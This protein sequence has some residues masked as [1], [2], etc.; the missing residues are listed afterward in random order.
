MLLNIGVFAQITIL[1]T[2]IQKGGDIFKLS[3]QTNNINSINP[4]PAGANYSWNFSTLTADAQVID[5]FLTSSQ[6]PSAYSL[7]FFGY[8]C[9]Q[10]S[11]DT[12]YINGGILSIANICNMYKNSSTTYDFWGCGGT[13]SGI[14]IPFNCS[15]HDIIYRFPMNYGN[16][17]SIDSKL[18]ASIPNLISFKQFRHRVNQVDG[19][20]SLI[21]PNGI[22][23]CLRLKSIIHDIDSIKLDTAY[24]HLP[25][26]II[27]GIQQTTI[28]YKWLVAGQGEP[29]LQINQKLSSTGVLTTNLVRWQNDSTLTCIP[30]TKNLIASI[31]AG[32]TF[33]FNNHQLSAAGIY[34]DTL[35]NAHGCDSTITLSLAVNLAL[36]SSQ[37]QSQS[38][39]IG[40]NILFIAASTNAT[41]FKWQTNIGLGWQNMSNAGQYN[42]VNNDTLSISS[43]TIANNNQLFRCIVSNGTCIDTSIV[44]NLNVCGFSINQQ[45]QSQTVAANTN[46]SFTVNTTG[47]G[48]NF[49]WQANAGL[50]FNNVSNAGS[51]S[52]SNTATLNI[53]NTPISFNNY[54][55]HCIITDGNCIDT[56]TDA[57]L[58]VTNGTGTQNIFDSKN[59]FTIHPNPNNGKFFI[60]FNSPNNKAFITISNVL[61]QI[62][63]QKEIDTKDEIKIEGKGIFFINV[64][65]K[66]I[67]QTKIIVI[68]N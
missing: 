60:E 56:T 3:S 35:T 52:G 34:Y 6:V 68:E 40:N 38:S 37:P 32:Q 54:I 53:S 17:D 28:E 30:T 67:S 46:T 44:A 63:E 62:I 22:F 1:N 10:N 66:N 29:L 36:I 21:M 18:F 2:D 8:N 33:T 25:I 43:I 31:C 12:S 55:F 49:K 13:I 11:P 50:G 41:N 24:T 61:G 14:P 4:V 5:T 26:V 58:T 65:S 20:G 16:N 19:W 47:T 39:S 23:N 59:E 15:P 27:Y 57:T 51:F 64:I 9:A 48:I 45:P 7:Y 42:G